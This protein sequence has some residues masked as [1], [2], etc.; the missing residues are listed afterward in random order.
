MCSLVVLP[1]DVFSGD[2]DVR[3]A[4]AGLRTPDTGLLLVDMPCSQSAFSVSA[5][6]SDRGRRNTL[7]FLV[8]LPNML[9]RFS[10]F[11]GGAAVGDSV[12]VETGAETLVDCRPRFESFR[13]TATSSLVDKK[14]SPAGLWMGVTGADFACASVT[15]ALSDDPP[16][17]RFIPAMW[18]RLEERGSMEGSVACRCTADVDCDSGCGPAGLPYLP[19]ETLL[20][21]RERE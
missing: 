5:G 6:V 8:S 12:V 11:S 14:A 15:S 16:K 10:F 9:V 3:A 19:V 17:R 13:F 20:V 1:S 21:F 4:M 18:L 2:D 7:N